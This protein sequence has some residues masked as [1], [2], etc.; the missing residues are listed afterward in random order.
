[1]SVSSRAHRTISQGQGGAESSMLRRRHRVLVVDDDDRALRS[2][3]AVLS[4]EVHVVTCTSAEQ[5][6]RLLE[7]EQFHLVCSD[8]LMPGMKGD[9]LLRRVS[10]MPLY[11]SG[12]LIT[13]A[14]EYLR[15]KD[16]SHSYVILK[17]FDPDRLIGL[18]L[19]LARLADMKRSVHSMAG[20]LGTTSATAPACGGETVSCEVADSCASPE[21]SQSVPSSRLV[22]CSTA[23]PGS[24][25]QHG[26]KS[27]RAERL[28]LCASERYRR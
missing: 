13:G 5:A 27:T 2:I 12:L 10:S 16:G 7:V 15:S 24:G 20:S 25:L 19:Q 9:E 18:V 3:C 4:A 28:A 8:F 11:T 6:L 21:S 22:A 17:P 26:P 23:A 1:M 14:D